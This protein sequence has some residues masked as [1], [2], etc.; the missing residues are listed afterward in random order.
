MGVTLK[1]LLQNGKEGS[2]SVSLGIIK[3]ERRPRTGQCRD[4]GIYTSRRGTAGRLGSVIHARVQAKHPAVSTNLSPS[5]FFLLSSFSESRRG[6]PSRPH[7]I[8]RSSRHSRGSTLFS[9]SICHHRRTWPHSLRNE[10]GIYRI[11]MAPLQPHVRDVPRLDTAEVEPRGAALRSFIDAT[12]F[13]AH[14]RSPT[15]IGFSIYFPTS[16]YGSFRDR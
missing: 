4:D 15:T 3:N 16:P 14:N 8:H 9:F 7:P 13:R 6:Y 11:Y 12:S 2:K 10:Y 1:R 5:T